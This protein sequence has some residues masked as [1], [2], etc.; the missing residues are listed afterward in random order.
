MIAPLTFEAL[1]THLD[2]GSNFK[3]LNTDRNVKVLPIYTILDFS[4]LFAKRGQANT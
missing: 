4:T 3:T 2:S 1:R